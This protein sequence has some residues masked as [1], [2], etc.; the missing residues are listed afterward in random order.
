MQVMCLSGETLGRY[1]Q[2]AHEVKKVFDNRK[3]LYKAQQED[4]KIWGVHLDPSGIARDGFD[5]YID[6][7]K[8]TLRQ[9]FAS[10]DTMIDELSL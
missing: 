8:E 2:K 10:V 4:T 1:S 3:I 9:R 6:F 7:L 5:A